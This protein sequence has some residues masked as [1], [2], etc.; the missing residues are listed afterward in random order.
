VHKLSTIEVLVEQVT[1]QSSM[2]SSVYE[3]W[4]KYGQGVRRLLMGVKSDHGCSGS[5]PDLEHKARVEGPSM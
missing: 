4:G 5:D 3:R 2:C 1:G